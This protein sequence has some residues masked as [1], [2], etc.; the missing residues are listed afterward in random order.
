MN[1][2]TT[3]ELGILIIIE[4]AKCYVQN[5]LAAST[6]GGYKTAWREFEHFADARDEPSLPTSA[7]TVIEYMAAL[8]DNGAMTSEWPMAKL[9][10]SAKVVVMLLVIG[11]VAL[12]V[13]RFV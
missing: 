12:L 9:L 8:A 1:E 10:L 2:L 3:R 5:T 7:V 4:G 13:R 11:G 6:L